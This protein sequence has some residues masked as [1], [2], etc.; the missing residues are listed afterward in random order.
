M[1]E[2]IDAYTRCACLN[3]V[4]YVYL[5]EAVHEVALRDG[6]TAAHHLLHTK[7]FCMCTLHCYIYCMYYHLQ[8]GSVRMKR[9]LYFSIQVDRVLMYLNKAIHK[10]ALHYG[11]AA[12]HHL[13]HTY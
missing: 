2:H 7:H 10:V 8:K 13:L 1:R 9:I 6:V 4:V 3:R 5:Y 11:V 12:A